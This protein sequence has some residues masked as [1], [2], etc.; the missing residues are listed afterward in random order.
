[1]SRINNR[2]SALITAAFVALGI[3]MLGSGAASAAAAPARIPIV[4]VAAASDVP[5]GVDGETFHT[6]AASVYMGSNSNPYLTG[7][8]NADGPI[9]VDDVLQI[10][11]CG[12][13]SQLCTTVYRH[14]FSN[15]CTAGGPQPLGP[16]FIGQY[17]NPGLNTLTFTLSDLCGQHEGSSDI[18]LTGNGVIDTTL[19]NSNVCKGNL[20][21][22]LAG[23]IGE[24]YYTPQ[25]ALPYVGTDHKI[26]GTGTV[27]V[28]AKV[29]CSARVQVTLQTR[30]CNRLGFNCHPKDIDKTAT[31]PLPDGGL[32]LKNLT[33]SCRS[34]K[35]DYRVQIHVSYTTFDSFEGPVPVLTA[36]D[37]YTPDGDQGWTSLNC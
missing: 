36:H 1:M 18:Y 31:D 17:L 9:Y 3:T 27:D 29:N 37:D 12:A 10:Q 34:G 28:H 4:Q 6:F 11:A 7:F 5:V 19:V 23:L 33:G 30:V 16:I 2:W 14:D 20:S 21:K 25:S 13:S 35:D 15:N 24:P 8:A 22:W 26:H 32:Y